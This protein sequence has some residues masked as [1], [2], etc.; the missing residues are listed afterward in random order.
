M[1]WPRLQAHEFFKR[2]D[3]AAE[4]HASAGEARARAGN[5]HWDACRGGFAQGRHHAGFI[6][7]DDHALGMAAKARCVLEISGVDVWGDALIVARGVEALPRTP[8]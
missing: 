8:V 4:R 2:Q 1:A 6:S 7:G 5:G 3:P